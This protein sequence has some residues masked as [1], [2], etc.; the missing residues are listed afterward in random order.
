[1]NKTVSLPLS[2]FHLASKNNRQMFG[3]RMRRRREQRGAE[4]PKRCIV[5]A[6]L[7]RFLSLYKDLWV[8]IFGVVIT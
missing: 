3:R 8:Q 6:D 4:K 7:S 1:M 2:P 5:T